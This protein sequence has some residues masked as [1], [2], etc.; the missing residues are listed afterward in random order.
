MN[1]HCYLFVF[2]DDKQYEAI[3]VCSFKTAVWQAA[4]YCGERSDL[5]QKSLNGFEETDVDGII[6]LFNHFSYVS[7]TK[8]YE[9]KSVVWGED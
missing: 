2:D 3:D 5:F 8:V 7:I 4:E 1:K 6:K 9:I